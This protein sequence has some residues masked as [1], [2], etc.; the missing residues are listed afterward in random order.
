MKILV[1]SNEGPN[2]RLSIP[3][4]LII[5]RFT[6]G[7]ITKYLKEQGLNISKEQVITFINELTR[8]A[9]NHPEW[10]L[11]EVEGSNGKYVKIKI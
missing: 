1:N 2:I 5:N 3:S 9:C 4:G 11:L 6:A 8:Y 7:F 10:M